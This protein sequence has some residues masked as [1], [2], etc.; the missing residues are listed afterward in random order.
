MD[1]FKEIST[2]KVQTFL[3]IKDTT[4]DRIVLN[5]AIKNIIPGDGNEK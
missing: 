3:V 2:S 5:K 1:D 4:D